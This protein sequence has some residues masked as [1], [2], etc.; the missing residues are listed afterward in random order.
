MNEW[1]E[2][3]KNRFRIEKMN[4]IHTNPYNSF[5]VMNEIFGGT[6]NS[7]SIFN[8]IAW[9]FQKSGSKQLSASVVARSKLKYFNATNVLYWRASDLACK[10]VEVHGTWYLN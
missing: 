9:F 5:T 7:L 1:I 2:L 4:T 6:A 8:S 10:S 3:E